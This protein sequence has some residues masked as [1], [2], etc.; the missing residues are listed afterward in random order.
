MPMLP[1]ERPRSKYRFSRKWYTVNQSWFSEDWHERIQWCTNNFGPEPKVEDA[2]C[3]WH[4]FLGGINF[5]DEKDYNWYQLRWG[6]A[7]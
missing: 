5:R 3:R 6:D 1:S 7:A 2:W 4:T